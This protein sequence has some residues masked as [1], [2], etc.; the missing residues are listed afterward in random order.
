MSS[1]TK[2]SRIKTRQFTAN[3]P[4]STKEIAATRNEAASEQN[5]TLHLLGNNADLAIKKM[6]QGGNLDT[7][8]I[9][10]IQAGID[11]RPKSSKDKTSNCFEESE[12]K[13]SVMIQ[14][15]DMI[16]K[17]NGWET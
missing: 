9:K 16:K 17:L 12:L 10:K 1:V 13:T 4:R 11:K 3:L 2:I 5:K 8:K 7:K 15:S 6:T 14:G